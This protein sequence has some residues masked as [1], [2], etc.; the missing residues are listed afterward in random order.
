MIS[1]VNT[2]GRW[3]AAMSQ[4]TAGGFIHADTIAG[5]VRALKRTLKDYRPYAVCPY[6]RDRTRPSCRAC[7]GK[8]F[9]IKVVYEQAPSE[10][11]M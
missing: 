5:Q 9:V 8:G 1:S 4:R 2:V 11:R 7:R 10:M 6:C 3:A